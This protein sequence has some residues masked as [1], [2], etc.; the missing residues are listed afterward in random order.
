MRL[1]SLCVKN[2]KFA[3]TTPSHQLA[4]HPTSSFAFESVEA[5]V[6]AFEH[7]MDEHLYSRFGNPTVD[8]V[9]QKIADLETYGMDADDAW[10]VM[11]SS[12]MAA[13]STLIF[14]TLSKGDKILS[15]AN[16]YGGSTE[17]IQNFLPQYG[18]DV[19]WTDL[20]DSHNVSEILASDP[21]IKLIYFETP[22]NP[23]LDCIDMSAIA[24][25]AQEHRV[26]TAIDNSFCSPVIQQ[27]LKHG[28]DYVIHSTT[29]YINGHGN[30]ISGIVVGRGLE[31]KK[32][33]WGAMKMVGTN[34]NPWDA[35]L[36]NMGMKT[37]ELR[38]KAHSDNAM[39]LAEFLSSHAQVASVN[40][41]GLADHQ[42]HDL[43]SRQM[44]YY[45]GMMCFEVKGGVEAGVR[46]MNNQTMG[47]LA[48]TM[49]DVDTLLMHPASMSH[50]NIDRDVRIA[51]GIGDGLIRVSVGIEDA[52]DMIEDF[53]RALTQG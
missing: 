15:Q 22:S 29:K 1:K 13:I 48:P 40:Y 17:I 33:I 38:M 26:L 46:F 21:T 14:A 35:W 23:A 44:R 43:A 11:T 45:G 52:Q 24:R 53:D 20:T 36:T 42:Y 5:T 19:V 28:I 41:L 10:G 32:T 18:I 30:G 25:V 2:P 31:R 34:C 47:T 12:G 49:G 8:A 4:I 51:H 37:L 50:R 6:H 16:L 3:E 9:A 39:A 27:P 7:P